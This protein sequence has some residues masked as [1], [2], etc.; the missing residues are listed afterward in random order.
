ME[1]GEFNGKFESAVNT[2]FMMKEKQIFDNYISKIAFPYFKNFAFHSVINFDFPLTIL[3]GKNGSGKSSALHA[4]Y[5]SPRG[6]NISDYWF[7]SQL[8]PIEDFGEVQERHCFFYEYLNKGDRHSVLYQKMNHKN[9]SSME[10]WETSRPRAKYGMA[11]SKT[12]SNPIEKNLVYIDFRKELSAFDKFFYFGTIDHLRSSS[13][14]DYLRLQSAKLKNLIDSGEIYEIHGCTQNENVIQ[15]TETEIKAVALI[16][17]E[18]YVDIKLINHKLFQG[19]GTSVIWS[20]NGFSYSEAH[21][22]S[23]EIAIVTL[24]HRVL[25]SPPRSLILLDEPEV[26]LHPGA[27]KLLLLFLLEQIKVNKHQIV[28]STHSPAFAEKM[29]KEAIKRFIRN[30]KSSKI[31]ILD[32]C[33]PSEAFRY[34][35]L[36]SKYD[37]A[38][39]HVE[40]HLAEKILNAVI[41]N[42]SDRFDN[43]SIFF[44]PG[45]ASYIKQ[46]YI[47]HYANEQ[48][49]NSFVIFDGDQKVNDICIDF[50]TLPAK[51]LDDKDYLKDQIKNFTNQDIDFVKDG[52]EGKKRDDQVVKAQKRYIEFYKNCVRFLPKLTPEEIIWDD[53]YVS[54]MILLQNRNLLGE[55]MEEKDYKN[56]ISKLSEIMTGNDNSASINIMQDMLIKKWI[57]KSDDSQ[58]AIKDILIEFMNIMNNQEVVLK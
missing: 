54:D 56:K 39:I 29:P 9:R 58:Q 16:L 12:R 55:V 15:L 1:V 30:P 20:K 6:T 14:Q 45:G 27:Q 48:T 36:S 19:W 5:G 37:N 21:A 22:G 13:K 17:Q 44:T 2:I 28:M 3:T 18:D 40:D 7:S 41:K 24:V 38:K 52:G 42:N 53:D 34:L 8:D 49:G 57:D 31:D 35:G 26:S 46:N 50:D 10:Y 51:L 47:Q 11:T 23:G 4:L 32:E 43:F 25:N 33:F